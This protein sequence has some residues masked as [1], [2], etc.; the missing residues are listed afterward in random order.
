MDDI[1]DLLKEAKPLYFKRKRIRNIMKSAGT[2]SVIVLMF[3]SF[4]QN[5]DT[6]IYD[7]DNMSDTINTVQNGSIIEEIGLPIDEYGFLRI[8]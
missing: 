7:F 3:F 4:L 1:S 6:Y 2:M 5:P 8:S